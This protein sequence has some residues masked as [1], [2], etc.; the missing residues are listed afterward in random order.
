MNA[1]WPLA[2]ITFKEGVRNRAF[3]GISIIALLLFAANFLISGLIMQDVGKVSVDIALSAVSFS[4]LLVVFFVGI[5]L[6]AKDLDRKTIYMVLSKPI[7]RSQYIWGKFFGIVL[8]LLATVVLLGSFS[9]ISIFLVKLGHP[10]FFPR[11]AWAPIVL[12]L[13]YLM[14]G[15]IMLVAISVLFSSFSSTSFITLVLTLIA[16]LIGQSVNDVKSLVEMSV[17]RGE[18]VSVVTL[19]VVQFAYYAFP[20]LSLFDLKLHAAHNLPLELEYLGW[21]LAYFLIYTFLLVSLAALIFRRKE[22]P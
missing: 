16:Y 13:V 2:L 10:L 8:L 9:L 6:L 4:G 12:A 3:Y 22:F 21:T 15:L 20:N 5:N 18:E 14:L 11:F 19:K 7:S 17:A 1:L